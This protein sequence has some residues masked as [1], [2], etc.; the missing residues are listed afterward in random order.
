[1]LRVHRAE[2]ADRLADCLADVLREPLEDPFAA[3]VISVPAKGVER[4][5]AQ[6]LSH[7][8]GSG[9]QGDGVC[10]NV[11]FPSVSTLVDECMAAGGGFDRAI[12]PWQPGRLVWVLLDV[13]DECA[14]QPWCGTL[15][16]YLGVSDGD[17]VRRGRRYAAAQHLAELFDS[18]GRH[19][20]DMLVCWSDGEDVDGLGDLLP[21]DLCWQAELWRQARKQLQVP[22]PAERLPEVCRA[23]REHPHRVALP[24]RLSI[25]G[26]T[27]LP[28]AHIRVLAALAERRDVH[29]WLPHPSPALWE[30]LRPHAVAR[31]PLARRADPTRDLPRHPLLASLG[32]EAREL[33]L[34]LAAVGAPATDHHHELAARADTSA[35]SR[36]AA[37]MPTDHHHELAARADTLLGRVQ[38]ALAGDDP[39]DRAGLPLLDPADR[40]VQVHACHGADRQVQVLREA[41]LGLLAEHPDLEPRDVL[42]M[43]P[44]IETFAPLISASFGLGG[45]AGDHPG[46]R[47]RVRL[48]DRA[49]R[50]VNPLLDT[51]AR[52]LELADSRLTAAQ[53]LDFVAA[54][55]VRRRFRLDDDDLERVRDLV[56]CS[57]V[58][59]GLDAG[60]RAR[61][62][63]GGIRPNTWA[64][65]L[66]RI[67]LGVAM[68]E[69]EQCW[70]DTA[71]PLDDVD[72]SDV[73]LVGRLA[74]VVDRLA[75]VLAALSGER[76]LADW[77]DAIAAGVDVLTAVPDSEAWQASQ[78]RGELAEVAA[79]AGA[80]VGRLRLS[81]PDVR[82]LLGERLR[83]RPTRANFRTGELTMC[84]MVPMRSVPHRVICLLGL[85]DGVF[86][87]T[88]VADGDDVLARDP[89][90]GERDARGEDRQLLLDAVLAAT[91]YLVV[92]YSGADE[93]SNARRPPAVPVDELIDTIDATVRTADGGRA[94]EHVVVA[95]PLQAFDGRNFTRGGLG[96]PGPFSFD[97][98]ALAGAVA[99]AGPRQGGRPLLSAPLPPPVGDGVVQLDDL[100]RFVEHPVRGFLR[101]RLGISLFTD[102]EDPADGLPVELDALE[103]W[104]VGDRLLRTRLGGA[105]PDRCVQA[106]WR[107]GTV[108]PGTLG[109]RLLTTLAADVQRLV[110]EAAPYLTGEPVAV[111][112]IATL[113]GGRS[114]AG[115]VS[116]VYEST[117]VTV[118]YSRLGPK[119]RLR[120]WVR[121]LALAAARPDRPW[122]AR[123]I[124]RGDRGR[125]SRST[126]GPVDVACA[127]GLLAGLVDLYGEGQREPL[128]LSTRASHAYACCRARG[129][130][131]GDAL[132]AARAEWT[133]FGAGA[134]GEDAAHVLVWGPAATLDVLLAEPARRATAEQT[135]FGEL[136]MRLWVPLLRAETLDLL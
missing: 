62:Q 95:H 32:R 28:A 85:D 19:R 96:V 20:P 70:L 51:V 125:L 97:R 55:P 57:G 64:A 135:R 21:P 22:S 49:L 133:R 79:A 102:D 17:R 23:L 58:R 68:S 16:S 39:P 110:A 101:Q 34:A 107:R 136:A 1:M 132:D 108:P 94:R 76:C 31:G 99:A 6:R 113:P 46:H 43:C 82:S 81:L 61:F 27:R 100:R 24:P 56:A 86:P 130:Q 41:V 25:F 67:L 78:V 98:T 45:E 71:L 88:A 12:D 119:H 91:E 74:E 92:V 10:A 47:L 18:Y 89:C 116:S 11:V 5:L 128:P 104:A 83:G 109:T 66:D 115:T 120:A 90:V 48:A 13:I 36:C 3:E 103:S 127:T 121:L 134:D 33:Q 106:E 112:L 30:R 117:I 29:L 72:S 126:I 59:W 77:L 114:V 4:W 93:H 53:V 44:D 37:G 52:L 111:D 60:H 84:T 38:A 35:G 2:R 65:G 9:P 118:E 42:V 69:D 131:V 124:G 73:E 26:P 40:S 105:D 50:Q 8:L 122:R 87:R 123:T 15:G 14:A 54:P 63:L 7:R 80:R 129:G 75:H